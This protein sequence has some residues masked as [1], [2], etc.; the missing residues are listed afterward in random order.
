MHDINDKDGDV[1]QRAASRAQVGKRF[2]PRSVDDQQPRNLVLERA[3]LVHHGGLGFDRLDGEVGRT[4]L[5]GD[6]SSLT[7][8]HIGLSNLDEHQPY[9]L[10]ASG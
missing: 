3:V 6:T 5:L 4:D 8:L 9:F 7:L 10:V 1:A 2:V